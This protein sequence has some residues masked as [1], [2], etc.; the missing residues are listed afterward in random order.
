MCICPENLCPTVTEHFLYGDGLLRYIP[1]AR[2]ISLRS[3]EL[4]AFIFNHKMTFHLK[5]GSFTFD[6]LILFPTI[7]SKEILSKVFQCNE[8]GHSNTLDKNVD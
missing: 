4:Q 3:Q 7:Y 8:D 6:L 2:G 1:L 5:D